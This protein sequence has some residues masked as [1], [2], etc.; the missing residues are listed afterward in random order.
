MRAADTVAV[1]EYIQHWVQHLTWT[2]LRPIR[3]RVCCSNGAYSGRYNRFEACQSVLCPASCCTV[4]TA[5]A[6]RTCEWLNSLTKHIRCGEDVRLCKEA[7]VF[8]T[9]SAVKWLVHVRQLISSQAAWAR[10]L[11]AVFASNIAFRCPAV[12]TRSSW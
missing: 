7:L 10:V 4:Q 2:M 3:L 12:A 8:F 5:S 6:H 11:D 1:F 9:V